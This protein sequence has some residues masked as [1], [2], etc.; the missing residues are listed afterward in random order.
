M[1]ESQGDHGNH[2]AAFINVAILVLIITG[3]A[4]MNSITIV[5]ALLGLKL[6]LW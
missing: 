1:K 3:I 4:I 2:S 6:L 5:I